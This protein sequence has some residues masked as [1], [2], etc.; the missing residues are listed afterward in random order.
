[1]QT[2]IAKEQTKL[3][4]VNPFPRIFFVD[5]DYIT[6]LALTNYEQRA[7][8]QRLEGKEG[9]RFEGNHLCVVTE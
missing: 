4:C 7:T 6:H 3:V 2:K 1:M 8:R 9:Q 5:I